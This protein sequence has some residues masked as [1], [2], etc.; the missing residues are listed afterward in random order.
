MNSTRIMS[1]K[2]I[3]IVKWRIWETFKYM[4]NGQLKPGYNL[5]IGV[6]SELIVDFKI[7]SNPTDSNTLIP[8]LELWILRE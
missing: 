6:S 1:S 8:F 7:F 2:N 5:Q 4:N 3:Q